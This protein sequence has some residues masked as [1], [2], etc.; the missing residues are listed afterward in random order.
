MTIHRIT[1]SLMAYFALMFILVA[2]DNS[3]NM[4]AKNK[5]A[6]FWVGAVLA[7]VA[8]VVWP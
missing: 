4:S 7:A 3:T 6:N 1:A 5:L 2:F 8:G